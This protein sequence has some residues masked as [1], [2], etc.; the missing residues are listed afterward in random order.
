MKKLVKL[1]RVS[2]KESFK[3]LRSLWNIYCWWIDKN[4]IVTN[5]FFR[6]ISGS[7]KSRTLKNIIERLSSV[8]LIEKIAR[9]WNLVEI[10]EKPIIEWY[11]YNKS[12]KIN[13]EISKIDFFIILWERKSWEIIL[14]SVFMN[15]L[16]K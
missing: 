2:S 3:K 10:R 15:Y 7:S 9:N 16:D 1:I 6:H 13:L 5:I 12:Y 8:N 14:I 4:F 11:E